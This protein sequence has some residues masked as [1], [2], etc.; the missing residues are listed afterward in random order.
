VA[1]W[2]VKAG[3]RKARALAPASMGWGVKTNLTEGHEALAPDGP[4]FMSR[5]TA[6]ARPAWRCPPGWRI[7]WCTPSQFAVQSRILH[8]IPDDI[9]ACV[10]S[11]IGWEPSFYWG[12]FGP[13]LHSALRRGIAYSWGLFAGRRPA[14]QWMLSCVSDSSLGAAPSRSNSLAIYDTAPEASYDGLVSFA[15]SY[16]ASFF[17][18]ESVMAAICRA[19]VS[20]ARLGLILLCSIV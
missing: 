2:L 7:T 13:V 15:G 17:Q 14:T 12:L 16:L 6:Q 5:Q 9:A 8:G 10:F 20:F 1:R 19:S 11:T 18:S 3:C 4:W